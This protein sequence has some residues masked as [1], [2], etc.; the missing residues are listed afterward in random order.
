MCTFNIREKF[1]CEGK[2]TPCLWVGATLHPLLRVLARY[3]NKLS[4]FVLDLTRF[5]SLKRINYPKQIYLAH[6]LSFDCFR[7]S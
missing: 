2:F 5:K 3:A 7:C 6:P 4:P 1:T